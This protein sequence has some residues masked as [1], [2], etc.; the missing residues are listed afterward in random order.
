MRLSV[1]QYE[2]SEQRGQGQEQNADPVDAQM[3]VEPQEI[4]LFN[5]LHS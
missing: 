3:N 1:E 2:Q 4:E 5:E